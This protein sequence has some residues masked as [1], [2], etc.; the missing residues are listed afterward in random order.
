MLLIVKKI[1]L[2]VVIDCVGKYVFS[3]DFKYFDKFIYM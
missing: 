3:Y 1:K 2:N